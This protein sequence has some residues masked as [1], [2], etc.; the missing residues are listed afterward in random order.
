MG[1]K[2]PLVAKV[3][4]ICKNKINEKLISNPSPICNPIPPLTFRLANETP[5]S[6]RIKVANGF[7]MR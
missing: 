6:V 2:F 3:V 5:I 7:E 1:D 4:E